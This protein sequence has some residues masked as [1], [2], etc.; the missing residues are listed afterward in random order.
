M[1]PDHPQIISTAQMWIRV[2]PGFLTHGGSPNYQVSRFS[3][4][5]ELRHDATLPTREVLQRSFVGSFV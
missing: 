1:A 3:H 4:R 5:D 2:N